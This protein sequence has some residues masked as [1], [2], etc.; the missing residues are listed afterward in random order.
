MVKISFVGAG[1]IRYT[2]KLVGDLAKTK[3]LSGSLVSLMDVDEERLE[4]VYNLAK[5]YTDEVGG[6]LKLEKTTDREKSL[7]G[8]DFVINTALYRAPGHEDGYVGY[9]IMRDV[10]EKYGYYRGID[11]QE[12]NMVSDYYTF[13]NY[14]HLKL[15]L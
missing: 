13:T 4:A 8:A 10:A 6:S 15:S 1:S 9:E 7:Q 11:S 12:F 3:E 14:N 2:L 5:R